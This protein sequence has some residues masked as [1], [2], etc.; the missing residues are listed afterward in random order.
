MDRFKFS[1]Y[2]LFFIAADALCQSGQLSGRILDSQTQEPLPFA[3]IFINNTTI[4]TTSD[5]DGNFLLQNVPAGSNEVIYSFIGY[6]SYTAKVT[7]SE[8]QKV[9]VVIRLIPLLQE[10]SSVEVKDTRDKAWI[11]QLRNFEKQFFGEAGIS[12]CKITNPWVIDFIQSENTLTANAT[13]PLEIVNSYLG[14]TILFHLKRFQSDNQ[15]YMIDGNAYFIKMSDSLMQQT[16]VKNRHEV[17]VGSERH[18]FQSILSNKVNE[19]GFRLYVDKKGEEDANLRSSQFYSDVGKKVIEFDPKNSVASAGRPYEFTIQLSGRTEVH[20][21][22]ERGARYYKDVT[23][24]VSWIEVRGNIIKVNSNGVVLNPG[25]VVYSGEMSNNRI[26]TLLPLDYEPE[27]LAEKTYVNNRT[28]LLE[29]V[30]LHTDKPYYYPG[31]TIWFKSYINGNQPI[32]DSTSK[33]LYVELINSSKQ[34]IQHKKIKIESG[35]A[36]SYFYLSDTLRRGNYLLRSYTNWSRNFGEPCYFTKPIPVLGMVEKVETQTRNNSSDST[37][38]VISDKE[39]YKNRERIQLTIQVLGRDYLPVKANL[40]VSVTDEKQVARLAEEVM[41]LSGFSLPDVTAPARFTFPVE[42]GIKLSGLLK[43]PKSKPIATI[44]TLV[45]GNFEEVLA[46]ETNAQ[47]Y[48]ELKGIEYYDSV[49]FAFQAKDK[50]GNPYGSVTLIS[51]EA[52]SITSWKQYKTLSVI[53]DDS[54]QRLLSE[55]EIP[56][57]AILL[58]EVT[59]TGKAVE[60]QGGK[61]QEK[62]FGKA[63]HVVNGNDLLASGATNLALALR[64]RIPGLVVAQ[65]ADNKGLHYTIK[66]RGAASFTL[67]T[68]PLVLM[69]GV[70]MVGA[71]GETAGDRLALINPGIVDRIEVTTRINSMYGDAGRNGVI[72]IYTKAGSTSGYSKTDRKT[73]H[74]FKLMGFSKPGA[75]RSPDYDD[76]TIEND[77]PDYRSTVYWNPSLE[78]DETTGECVVSFFAT[79]LSGRYRVVVEG[80]TEMGEPVRSETFIVIGN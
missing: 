68:E 61:I 23:G 64:G 43:D 14:Y 35:S 55:Y 32:S 25:N 11:K 39:I 16:W 65:E 56:K 3:H 9:S 63:D 59:V 76:P 72:A 1:L 22:N 18:L 73:M 74:V 7:I 33:V 40:S 78:S 4:G 20:Y 67:S 41:I 48:F 2:F 80:V 10:L 62:V 36:A 47:G 69:D 28:H 50:R 53:N 52:P 19:A 29:K 37:I 79:D 12:Q 24:Q 27:I 77:K 42:Q 5:V 44:L 58:E 70:P 51:Q 66:I 21:L 6:Q 71:P 54:P 15:S 8:N 45:I 38:K 13:A 46:L 30:Y 75:F 31:E 34:V 57:D 17:Y 26:G 60:T 49:E